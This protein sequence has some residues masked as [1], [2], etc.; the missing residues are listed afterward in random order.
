MRR[1]RRLVSR[2]V[3]MLCFQGYL[4]PTPNLTATQAEEE[5]NIEK[6]RLV[7]EEKIKISLVYER[8]NKQ[9]EI[10]KKMY[11]PWWAI[12][13]IVILGRSVFLTDK[14]KRIHL[15]TR[16]SLQPILQQA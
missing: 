12:R 2:Y 8:K 3:F 5:F 14:L 10:K 4:V 1:P 16:L 7:Q 9:I 11:V 15:L 6:A 13:C